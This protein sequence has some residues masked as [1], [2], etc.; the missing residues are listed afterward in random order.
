[1]IPPSRIVCDDSPGLGRPGE[2]APALSPGSSSEVG[3]VGHEESNVV[4]ARHP[5]I[6]V[7]VVDVGG[8]GLAGGAVDQG[9]TPA[10]E[11]GRLAANSVTE[12]R[13]EVAR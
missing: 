13:T 4:G 11:A 10:Y 3:L 8:Y 9:D 5:L 2:R 12:D 7:D 6:G 1:V